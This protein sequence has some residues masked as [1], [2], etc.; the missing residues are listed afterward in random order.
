MDSQHKD[1]IIAEGRSS[2]PRTPKRLGPETLFR[3]NDC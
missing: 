2:H 1:P 3:D